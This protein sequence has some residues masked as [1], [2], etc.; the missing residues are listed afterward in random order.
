[1]ENAFGILVSWLR[2]LLCA[3]NHRLTVVG[4]I[5][6]TYFV[7]HNMVRTHQCGTD[8]VPTPANDV[9]T[10]QNEQAVCVPNENY[11]NHLKEAKHQRELLTDYFNHMGALAG[12]EDRI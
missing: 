3:M 4:D 1:M 6:F 9:E 8:R 7:L 10:L 5:V 2:V 11:R 12:Q